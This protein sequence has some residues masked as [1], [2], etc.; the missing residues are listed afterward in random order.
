MQMWK[1]TNKYID[2]KFIIVFIVNT[3]RLYYI[4]IIFNIEI[5]HCHEILYVLREKNPIFSVNAKSGSL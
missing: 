5:K 1:E 4:N 3:G 2:A